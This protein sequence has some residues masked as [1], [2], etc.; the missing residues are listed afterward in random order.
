MGDK[1]QQL[2]TIEAHKQPKMIKQGGADQGLQQVVGQ[3]HAS[4]AGDSAHRAET[5]ELR[6]VAPGQRGIADSLQRG[7]KFA[8]RLQ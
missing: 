6:P 2:Q 3:R 5:A 1:G 7:A 4:D 8:R